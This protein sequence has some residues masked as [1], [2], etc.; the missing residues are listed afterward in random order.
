MTT[1][2]DLKFF[3]MADPDSAH[4]WS[5]CYFD[6]QA[7]GT[8]QR[9]WNEKQE[10]G[11]WCAPDLIGSDTDR[12]E[13]PDGKHEG[14]LYG[15]PVNVYIWTDAREADYVV[16]EAEADTA[17]LLVPEKGKDAAIYTRKGIMR[18][19]FIVLQGDE[20]ANAH[21]AKKMAEKE[22]MI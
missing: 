4:Q 16:T 22:S 10:E 6:G 11:L 21:A 5:F 12:D 15:E 2:T 1:R 18:H 7:E 17:H 3:S 14:M 13:V 19:G 20:K 8:V 9:M